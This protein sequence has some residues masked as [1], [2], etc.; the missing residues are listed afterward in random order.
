MVERR[1][2]KPRHTHDTLYTPN[3]YS[4]GRIGVYVG[5]EKHN[6]V[7]VCAVI[8]D[9]LV[10]AATGILKQRLKPFVIGPTKWSAVMKDSV[11]SDFYDGGIVFECDDANW[12]HVINV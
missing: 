7:Y 10:P 8:A 12:T 9:G 2:V 4:V 11:D 5:E 3:N 6:K 1:L